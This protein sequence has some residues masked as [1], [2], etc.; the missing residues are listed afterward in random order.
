MIALSV[1]IHFS[2][3]TKPGFIYSISYV[4]PLSILAL[5]LTFVIL[6]AK[7]NH[8]AYT[9]L[10]MILI[11][12]SIIGLAILY[13]VEIRRILPNIQEAFN[14]FYGENWR[15]VIFIILFFIPLFYF[16]F[17]S[18]AYFLPVLFI[19]IALIMSLVFFI[20]QLKHR[21]AVDLNQDISG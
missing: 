11:S 10:K 18:Y 17:I 13:I 3:I 1:L 7:L 19:V 8:K 4:I 9:Y 20:K 14:F 6:E 2:V 15:I 12:L 16:V 5:L 21:N